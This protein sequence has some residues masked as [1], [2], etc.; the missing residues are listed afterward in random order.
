M[1][2]GFGGTG[3]FNLIFATQQP[4]VVVLNHAGYDA[5]NEELITAARGSDLQMFWSDPDRAQP[6]GGFDYRAF[7]SSWT[8]DVAQHGEELR[9]LLAAL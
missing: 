5:R 6:A 9:A 3:L 4:P 2:A 1:V 8:F 7:Q